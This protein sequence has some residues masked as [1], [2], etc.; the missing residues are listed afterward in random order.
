[1]ADDDLGSANASLQVMN[2][3]LRIVSQLAGAGLFA[4]AGGGL[5]EAGLDRAA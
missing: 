1:M 5:A 3:G 4:L 2:Q